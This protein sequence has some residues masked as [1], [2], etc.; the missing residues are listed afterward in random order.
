[1]AVLSC[2]C[3]SVLIICVALFYAGSC[4]AC[5][6]K[7]HLSR[8]CSSGI[9]LE[10]ISTFIMMCKYGDLNTRSLVWIFYYAILLTT[11][12]LHVIALSKS[13]MKMVYVYAILSII[14]ALG[15][16]LV[17]QYNSQNIQVR[18]DDS[19]I[20][21]YSTPAPSLHAIGVI[22]FFTSNVTVHI[23]LWLD[24][25]MFVTRSSKIELVQLIWVEFIEHTFY[26]T[27]IA[28]FITCFILQSVLAAV[29]LEYMVGI[30]YATMFV[31]ALNI[32]IRFND[33]RPDE[34]VRVFP[35]IY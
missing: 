33:K 18:S 1:M 13:S 34:H 10:Y 2:I 32:Y 15:I 24:N 3:V 14:S 6:Y 4:D 12:L 27:A 30:L 16:S 23:L 21:S 20:D 17:F 19:Y 29:Y 22:L 7:E 9:C 5:F 25:Y 26:I 28:V 8:V 35:E 31:T 11:L